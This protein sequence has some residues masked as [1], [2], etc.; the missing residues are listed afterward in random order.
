MCTCLGRWEYQ[1]LRPSA[2]EKTHAAGGCTF[3]ELHSA[4]GA[5]L[6]RSCWTSSFRSAA[7]GVSLE[8]R[9]AYARREEKSRQSGSSE[10]QV[11]TTA[12]AISLPS[13]AGLQ[14]ILLNRSA[15]C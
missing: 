7:Q 3:S 9:R 4:V 15:S 13:A 6:R 10:I 8:P 14:T 12:A 5:Y 1:R 11:L 2:L